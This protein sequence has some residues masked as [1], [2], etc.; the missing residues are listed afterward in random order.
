MKSILSFCLMMTLLCCFASFSVSAAESTTPQILTNPATSMSPL[1][2]EGASSSQEVSVGSGIIFQPRVWTGAMNLKHTALNTTVVTENGK[3]SGSPFTSNIDL[4]STMPVLGIGM[5]FSF[6]RFILDGYVQ[7]TS[8][9]KDETVV[10]RAGAAQN[11][12]G[13]QDLTGLNLTNEVHVSFFPKTEKTSYDVER[14]D[15][16]ISLGYQ[17][18]DRFV[19]FGGYRSGQTSYDQLVKTAILPLNG[20]IT[21]ETI[22]D[23]STSFKF[24]ASGPFLGLS[25]NYPIS[26]RGQ[27]GFNVAYAQLDGEYGITEKGARETKMTNSTSGLTYGITW[28]GTLYKNLSYGLSLDKYDYEFSELKFS[29]SMSSDGSFIGNHTLSVKDEILTFKFTLSYAF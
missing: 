9:G 29:S 1:G 4:E 22:D 8:S 15:Y 21:S 20:G 26:E 16:S 17:V 6:K 10:N 7:K 2:T 23:R 12:I 27:L 24:K 28:R 5:A 18:T 3:P 13:D 25:Y 11:F 19:V 14:E